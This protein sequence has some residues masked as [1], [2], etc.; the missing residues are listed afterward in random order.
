M[1]S[2][3]APMIG[4]TSLLRVVVVLDDDVAGQVHHRR[5]HGEARDRGE[6]RRERLRG[7][8]RSRQG[9]AAVGGGAPACVPSCSAIRFGSGRTQSDDRAARRAR[10]AAREPRHGERFRRRALAGEDRAEDRPA[11][12]SRRRPSRRARTTI[13]RA[14][15]SGGYMSPAAVR[16]SSATRPPRRVRAKPSDHDGRRAESVPSASSAQPSDADDEADGDHRHRGRSDPSRARPGTR[17]ERAD[18]AGRSPGRG[19]R[20]P[21]AGD[22]HERDDET[23]AASCTTA[24][25]QRAPA[26]SRSVLRRMTVLCE[27]TRQRRRNAC[28]PPW[29][30]WR[31][32]GRAE[33]AFRATRPTASDAPAARRARSSERQPGRRPR[34]AVGAAVRVSRSPAGASARR[35]S[36]STSSSRPSS[37]SVRCTIVA[38]ASAGPVPVSCRSE[39]NGMPETLA[40]R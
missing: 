1:P 38:L 27:R 6:Q 7:G 4:K 5:H 26:A 25:L 30:G 22:E 39:V 24:E 9:A 11:R 20:S 14:R 3:C 10:G 36:R 28:A 32:Y 17:G 34:R 13:P 40:P 12:G 15:R 2:T 31:T 18:D 29:D 8:A 19:P 37:A 21:G 23:A 35:S 16:A 33:R